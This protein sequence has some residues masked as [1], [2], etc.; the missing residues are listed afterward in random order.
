VWWHE[1]KATTVFYHRIKHGLFPSLCIGENQGT[2]LELTN[3]IKPVSTYCKLRV[4]YKKAR[5]IKDV[6]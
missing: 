2:I 5:E 4:I 3:E 1:I 6:P